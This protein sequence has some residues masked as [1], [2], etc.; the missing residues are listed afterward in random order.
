M[1]QTLGFRCGSNAIPDVGKRVRRGVVTEG[2]GEFGVSYGVV[3]TSSQRSDSVGPS[4]V[5]RRPRA[6]SAYC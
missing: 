5:Q 2:D 3:V 4:Q 1:V 6:A